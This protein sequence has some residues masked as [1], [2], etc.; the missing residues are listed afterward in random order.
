MLETARFLALQSQTTTKKMD[1]VQARKSMNIV[2]SYGQPRGMFH[3][4][5]RFNNLKV[6]Q[7]LDILDNDHNSILCVE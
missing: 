7:G 6:R 2:N 5:G 3:A 1:L 4:T